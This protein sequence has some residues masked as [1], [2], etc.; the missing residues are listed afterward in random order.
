M[1]VGGAFIMIRKTRAAARTRTEKMCHHYI[2]PFCWNSDSVYV[3]VCVYGWMLS[4]AWVFVTTTAPLP[5]PQPQ[6]RHTNVEHLRGDKTNRKEN[7]IHIHGHIRT[8]VIVWV[9]VHIAILY[10]RPP[11]HSNISIIFASNNSLTRSC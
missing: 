1:V 8:M 6:R 11:L 7:N 4:A 2:R 10:C 3:C 9:V 5:P